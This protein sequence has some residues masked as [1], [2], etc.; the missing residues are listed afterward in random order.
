M[1]D[2]KL[3]QPEL[4]GIPK[5]ILRCTV[6]LNGGPVTVDL[7][8][9]FSLGEDRTNPF[10]IQQALDDL[11]SQVASWQIANLKAMEAFDNAKEE[12]DV[13]SGELRLKVKEKIT[14][15]FKEKGMKPPTLDDIEAAIQKY[16]IKF[17][18][19]QKAGKAVE[20][21]DK[22]VIECI[23]R[24]E[25][26]DIAEKNKQ[27]VNLIATVWS[28]RSYTLNSM[29][30]CVIAMLQAEVLSVKVGYTG[31]KRKEKKDGKEDAS[32]TE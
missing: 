3:N 6:Q 5:E 28:S 27:L 17:W 7:L 12:F 23:R 8:Q 29:A 15:E 9:E 2:T 22:Y 26:M 14:D 10:V 16:Y 32:K 30:N 1:A 20:A 21:E 11:P 31:N 4:Q 18:L 25:K 19:Q 24:R 13:F